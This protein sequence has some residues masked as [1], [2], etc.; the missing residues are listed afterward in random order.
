MCYSESE[1]AELARRI[2]EL[3][4]PEPNSGCLLFTG[5]ESAKGYPLISW[6]GRDVRAHRAMLA[7]KLGRVLERDELACH[8]CDVR[9]CCEP[10]H[11]FPGTNLDNVRDKCRKGRQARVHGPRKVRDRREAAGIRRSRAAGVPVRVIAK[12]KGLSERQVER[13]CAGTRWAS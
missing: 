3:C 10:Q 9:C 13:I 2:E 8:T 5:R 4:V 11:L 6:R 1:L 12:R 7:A